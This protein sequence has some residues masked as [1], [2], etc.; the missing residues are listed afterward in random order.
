MFFQM[1]YLDCIQNKSWI[2]PPSYFQAPRAPISKAPY[3]MALVELRELKEQL[4]NYWI[5]NWSVQ[6][7]HQAERRY[8]LLKNRMGV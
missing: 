1:T 8:Y 3:K 6:V 7:F 4:M 5:R 2:S